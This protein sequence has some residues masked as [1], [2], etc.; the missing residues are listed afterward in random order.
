MKLV[1]DANILVGELLRKRGRELL[2]RTDLTLHASERVMDESQYELNRR[3]SQMVAQNL[4]TQADGQLLLNSAQAVIVA[5]VQAIAILDFLHLETEAR[6]R[7]PRDPNDWETVAIALL[8]NAA[9]WTQDSDFLG[10]G[11]PTWT[12]ETL[13]LNL[14]DDSKSSTEPM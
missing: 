11:C 3:V 6:K 7:I 2:R 4:F 10:C 5:K 1:V 8:L 14:A 13:L 12:T 9:I